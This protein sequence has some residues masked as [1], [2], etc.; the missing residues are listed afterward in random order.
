MPQRWN[1]TNDEH[2][3]NFGEYR[4]N[5]KL[6]GKKLVVEIIPEHRSLPQNDLINT[7]YAEIGRQVEDQSVN[8]IRRECKL[9]YGVPILRAVNE[10]FRNL[11]DNA[12]KN[13]LTY[14]QKLE[15]MD[16]LPVTSLMNK[17]QATAYIDEVI[18]EYSKQGYRLAHPSEVAA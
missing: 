7:L 14:E 18:R 5:H 6:A 13:T 4:T 17:K 9:R 12:I 15:A 2:W 3:R 8:E 10:R 11:Y 1:L 16:I